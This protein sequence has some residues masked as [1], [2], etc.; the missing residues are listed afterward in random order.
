MKRTD[1]FVL[2]QLLAGILVLL[3]LTIMLTPGLMNLAEMA[4][5]SRVEEDFE[6]LTGAFDRFYVDTA[7]YPA[8]APPG[9]DPGLTENFRLF[10]GWNGPYLEAWPR[11]PLDSKYRYLA[12]PLENSDR[13]WVGLQ[14]YGRDKTSWLSGSEFMAKPEIPADLW[15]VEREITRRGDDIFF[16]IACISLEFLASESRPAAEKA[17]SPTALDSLVESSNPG[18]VSVDEGQPDTIQFDAAEPE[19]NRHEYHFAAAPGCRTGT[20]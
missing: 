16:L 11:A 3:A 10:P 18:D 2:L 20:G 4:A 15:E 19:K 1:G 13:I 12:L 9:T 14:F 6:I 8:T 17:V 5:E 7:T